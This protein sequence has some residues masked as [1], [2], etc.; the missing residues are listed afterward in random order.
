MV[1]H[2]WIWVTSP[3]V[4]IVDLSHLQWPVPVVFR[5]GPDAAGVGTVAPCLLKAVSRHS[6]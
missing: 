5:H 2:Y 4:S 3:D 1:S 6:G